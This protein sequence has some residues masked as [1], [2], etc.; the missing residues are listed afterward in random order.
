MA[1]VALPVH[2]S[3]ATNPT[4]GGVAPPGAERTIAEAIAGHRAVR[5]EILARTDATRRTDP[6]SLTR[7]LDDALTALRR[8][9]AE[10]AHF[11][12]N[13]NKHLED[14]K[15]E[16]DRLSALLERARMSPSSHPANSTAVTSTTMQKPYEKEISVSKLESILDT[17]TN[18]TSIKDRTKRRLSARAT[19]PVWRRV[20][21][22][23]SRSAQSVSPADLDA[24]S[25]GSRRRT[26]RASTGGL[27]NRSS[28]SF[29]RST[30]S[31]RTSD[32]SSGMWGMCF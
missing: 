3:S 20:S 26:N 11:R 25:L 6:T 21:I 31:S 27:F 7:Q 12:T 10:F 29:P 9:E 8:L 1:T 13:A 18:S 16:N 15:A 4:A 30:R 14:A 19:E 22:S 17:N 32:R 5:R 2:S 23:R 24:E 28:F